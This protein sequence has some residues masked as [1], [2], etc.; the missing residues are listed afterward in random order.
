ML[1]DY[2]KALKKN[3]AAQNR[4]FIVETSYISNMKKA[5]IQ[6]ID[7]RTLEAAYRAMVR[8]AAREREADGWAEAMIG[9]IE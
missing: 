2:D 4:C 6:P 5:Q 9:D 7:A 1:Q 8:D 3:A